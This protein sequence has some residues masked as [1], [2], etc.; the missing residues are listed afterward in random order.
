MATE[1]DRPKACALC[2][3]AVNLHL[4][5]TTQESDSSPP[6]TMTQI[7]L[8]TQGLTQSLAGLEYG[9]VLFPA[10]SAELSVCWFPIDR[11]AVARVGVV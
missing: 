6:G 5:L 11:K 8:S 4:A 9:P 7:T 3:P 2:S 10:C 1:Y